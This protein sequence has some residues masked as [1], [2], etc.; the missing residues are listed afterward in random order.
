MGEVI[1]LSNDL[2][3]IAS[4]INSYKQVAGLSFVEIGRRL[5]HVKDNDLVRGEWKGFLESIQMSK[6]Q[7]D[8]FITIAREYEMGKLP[9]VGNIGFRAL[10]EIATMPEEQ[11]TKQHELP[12]GEQKTPDEM[13]IKELREV[14]K[15]LKQAEARAE[16]AKKSE[17]IALKQLEEEQNKEP[18]RI[19]VV[20]DDYDYIKG[21]YESAV[22][23]RDRYKEQLEEMRQELERS[24]DKPKNND[25]EIESLKQKEEV[26]KSKIN[27]YEKLFD[28]QTNLEMILSTIQPKIHLLRTENIKDE[29]GIIDEFD[30][31]LDEVIKVC[32]EFKNRLP[33]KNIIEGEIVNE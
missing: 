32:K 21:N 14:K 26:L 10:Y 4:E 19:E 23:L 27:S 12:S 31:T 7:A 33:N 11:R 6:S 20:P 25:H 17:E 30:S 1:K 24:S 22:S 18:E 2:N 29:Y 13:T 5:M 15:Q 16:Q 28:I 9:H 8:R 3:V